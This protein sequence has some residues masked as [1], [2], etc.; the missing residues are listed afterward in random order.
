MRAAEL[1][2]AD[3]AE[4]VRQ[5]VASRDMA[6]ARDIPAVI[7]ARMRPLVNAMVPRPTGQWADRVPQVADQEIRTWDWSRPRWSLKSMTH[8]RTIPTGFHQK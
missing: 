1:A 2:G 6:G 5:A 3:P 4:I 8:C 7:D